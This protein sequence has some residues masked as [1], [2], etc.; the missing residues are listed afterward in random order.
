MVCNRSPRESVYFE[1][2]MG[3]V[4]SVLTSRM[5]HCG[6]AMLHEHN[7][8]VSNL[9]P[10]RH[11]NHGTYEDI[12]IHDHPK[13]SSRSRN[14]EARWLDRDRWRWWLHIYDLRM[15]NFFCATSRSRWRWV[16]MSLYNKMHTHT[17]LLL[18]TRSSENQD[19]MIITASTGTDDPSIKRY[20]Y[21]ILAS[22]HII[23]GRQRHR[24]ERFRQREIGLPLAPEG[25][26]LTCRWCFWS[27]SH[28]LLST[29]RVCA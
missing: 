22:G 8:F 16:F 21:F 24:Q 3:I 2:A 26:Y 5:Q 29:L 27:F 25:T 4:M 15:G 1:I 18:K 28:P 23:D 6:Q 7:L 13:L 10:V 20:I 9:R 14:C 19:C 17:T 11:S 12:Y